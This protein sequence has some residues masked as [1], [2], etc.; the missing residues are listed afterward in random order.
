MVIHWQGSLRVWPEF[1]PD[2]NNL[3]AVTLPDHH[4]TTVEARPSEKAARAPNPSAASNASPDHIDWRIQ[5][6]EGISWVL[7]ELATGWDE[8]GLMVYG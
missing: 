7:R 8:Q 5:C 3:I 1:R 2:S 4:N 6:E